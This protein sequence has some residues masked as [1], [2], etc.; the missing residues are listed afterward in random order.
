[1]TAS[2]LAAL[3]S[4]S[5]VFGTTCRCDVGIGV[6]PIPNESWSTIPVASFGMNAPRNSTGRKVTE[7]DGPASCWRF[8]VGEGRSP[9]QNLLSLP[10]LFLL[11]WGSGHELI[12][13]ENITSSR[14]P[15]TL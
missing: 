1:M 15:L 4:A 8:R 2:E 12:G 13:T 3:R 5:E 9:P 10:S 14:R 11:R 7:M 6:E